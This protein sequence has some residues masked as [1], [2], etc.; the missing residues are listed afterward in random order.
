MSNAK[1]LMSFKTAFHFLFF[2]RGFDTFNH[3]EDGWYMHHPFYQWL[4]PLPRLSA[5]HLITGLRQ[6]FDPHLTSSKATESRWKPSI[7]T[8]RLKHNL[9]MKPSLDI[10]VRG[11][12]FK[13]KAIILKKNS[14]TLCEDV[15]HYKKD[16][17]FSVGLTKFLRLAIFTVFCWP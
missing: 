12:L 4:H 14:W 8:L 16:E 13:E 7:I 15:P 9:W 11:T 3:V 6:A 17:N 10:R 1:W 2:N 5:L